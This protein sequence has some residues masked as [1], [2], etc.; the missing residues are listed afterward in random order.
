MNELRM[1]VEHLFEGRV[2]TPENIELKEEIYGNL[3]ARYEDYVASGMDETEA[4]KRTKAS[5]TSLD[6]LQEDDG[7]NAEPAQ[8]PA[9]EAPAEPAGAEP[10]TAGAEPTRAMP[11]V[12][13]PAAGGAPQAPVT[14]AAND[15]AKGGDAARP[16]K[17]VAIIAA[18][19]IL[20]LVAAL[21]VYEIAIGPMLDH[22]EDMAEDAAELQYESQRDQGQNQGAGAQGNTANGQ[23]AQDGV[24]TTP[25][26]E[27]DEDRREYEATKALDDARVAVTAETLSESVGQAAPDRVFFQA[28][29]LGDTIA[30]TGAEQQSNA[31]FN[32]YYDGVSEDID[33]DA[34]DRALVFNA[35]VAF[36]VYPELQTLNLTVR[37]EFESDWDLEIYSFDR[38]TLEHAFSNATDGAIAQLDATQISTQDALNTL[39]SCAAR[40]QFCERQVDYAEVQ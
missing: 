19:V 35:A 9:A 7:A 31:S 22:A 16:W 37:E 30:S 32:V 25:R 27:D 36:C 23:G 20:V 21:G 33:G 6:D 24:A 34:V 28:L 39:R 5:F 11:A 8:A 38:A 13:A 3:V 40:E 10:A 26:F 2:L 1:Y 4:L 15:A 18:A 17:K 14:P 12:A 29:P